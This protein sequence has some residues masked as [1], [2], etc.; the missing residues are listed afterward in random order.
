MPANHKPQGIAIMSRQEVMDSYEID[1]NLIIR[2]PGKFESEF[3]WA[4]YF[5]DQTLDG[6]S[7]ELTYPNGVTVYAVEIDETDRAEWPEIGADIVAALLEES[8]NGFVSCD[9]VTQSELDEQ[10]AD[11]EEANNADDFDPDEDSEEEPE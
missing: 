5:W 11:C 10:E 8:D 6:C 2:S 7:D 3:A 1:A 4:P 9:L